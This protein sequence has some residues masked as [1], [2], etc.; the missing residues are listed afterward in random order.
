MLL[1][2]DLKCADGT[3]EDSSLLQT[4]TFATHTHNLTNAAIMQSNRLVTGLD[5]GTTY[6][7]KSVFV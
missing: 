6:T 1:E 3:H 7:G 2:Q 4:P 5:Y